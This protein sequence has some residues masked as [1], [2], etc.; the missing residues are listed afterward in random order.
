MNEVNSARP[1]VLDRAVRL[2]AAF[3]SGE[4]A[5]SLAE[6]AARTELPKSSVHR[7]AA[8][9][10]RQNLMATDGS[11]NYRL[12]LR[13]WELGAAAVNERL[14]LP[15]LEVY[16]KRVAAD[17]D[18]TCHVG[19]LDGQD[20]VY[21]ARVSSTRAVTVQTQLGQRVPAHATAT[22]IA[23]L[24]AL[25]VEE[26]RS[27]FSEPLELFTETTP[28]T[29]D[30]LI[31]M[32]DEAR[33]RGCSLMS[34]GRQADTCGTAAPIF[35]NSGRVIASIG[36]AGPIYR[37]SEERLKEMGDCV[38]GVAA[39]ISHELLTGRPENGA[40]QGRLS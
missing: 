19:V 9:L 40:G 20:V 39:E 15:A 37:T 11:G 25:P 1:G 13:L 17:W 30:E 21:V 12:G 22:G 33:D 4:T 10:V 35:G 23:I 5:L 29:V 2:L 24:S 16:A 8:T 27:T 26:I 28:R 18:E 38:K 32:A 34:P 7:F 14:P 31:V 3:E 6:L 36:I